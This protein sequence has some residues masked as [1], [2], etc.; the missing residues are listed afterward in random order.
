MDRVAGVACI[1]PRNRPSRYC[2][3]TKSSLWSYAFFSLVAHSFLQSCQWDRSLTWASPREL[4]R[5]ANDQSL[6]RRHLLNTG[7]LSAGLLLPARALA[8]GLPIPRLPLEAGGKTFL[9][10]RFASEDL[11][12]GPSGYITESGPSD[13]FYPAW[14]EGEW[15]VVQ[16]LE[17]YSAP[18]GKKFISSSVEEADKALADQQKQLGKPVTVTLRYIRTKRG[19]LVEDRTNN[20]AQ[21]LDAFA[22]RQVVTNT[23]YSDAPNF[24]REDMIK[25]GDGPDDPL[26]TTV[27][28]FKGAVQ[29]T[30]ITA[31]ETESGE[32]FFRGLESKRSLYRIGTNAAFAVDEEVVTGLKRKP[33]GTII[34]RLRLLGYLNPNNP[35]F[36][37]TQNKAVTVADYSLM[38]SKA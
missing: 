24:G 6:Q 9:Q 10:K 21:R 13:L 3:G 29:K 7:A 37:E 18:L 5:S 38:F 1:G 20:L 2:T 27:V 12:K 34:G 15:K 11:E 16:T 30:F 23:T 25:K 14:M 28:Y 4:Q 22:G 19:N 26:L 31:F 36:F 17:K 8:D 35:S 33:D 32:N